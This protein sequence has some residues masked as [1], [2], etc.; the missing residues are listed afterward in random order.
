MTDNTT[1][2]GDEPFTPMTLHL[3]QQTPPVQ[4]GPAGATAAQDGAS[5]VDPSGLLGDL[6]KWVDHQVGNIWPF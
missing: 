6:G 4:R 3:P 2:W 1:R 5:G